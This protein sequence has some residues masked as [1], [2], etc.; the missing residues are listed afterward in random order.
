[1]LK[2]LI[3]NAFTNFDPEL[4]SELFHKGMQKMYTKGEVILKTG[5]LLS[6]HI[7]FWKGL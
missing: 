3:E 1:M 7:L 2:S 4:K 6:E 5:V